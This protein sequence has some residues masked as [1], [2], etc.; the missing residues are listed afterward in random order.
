MTT[1]RQTQKKFCSRALII[2]ILIGFGLILSGYKPLGKG[3]VLGTLFSVL[4]FILMGEMLA[5]QLASN[6]KSATL[7][8]FGAICLRYAL[9]AIPVIVAVKLDSIHVLGVIVGLFMIQLLLIFDGLWHFK[10]FLKR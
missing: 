10:P 3:L 2:S 8:S 9:L 1:D 5:M 7:R 6:K 4:N